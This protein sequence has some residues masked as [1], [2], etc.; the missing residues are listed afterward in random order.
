MTPSLAERPN[1]EP[2][3]STIALIGLSAVIGEVRGVSLDAGPPPLMSVPTFAP[4]SNIRTVTPVIAS[5]SCAFPI[6]SPC[7][8][9]I[10]ISFTKELNFIMFSLFFRFYFSVKSEKGACPI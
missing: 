5:K 10:G 2:P 3:D 8:S 7:I 6:R 9:V 1:A 4:S